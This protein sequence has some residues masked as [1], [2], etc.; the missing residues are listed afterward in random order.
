MMS[1]E[2][3]R[4]GSMKDYVSMLTN[5]YGDAERGATNSTSL[6]G[7]KPMSGGNTTT[8]NQDYKL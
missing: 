7:S 6:G 8:I 4:T 1:G 3:E 5:M 2:K